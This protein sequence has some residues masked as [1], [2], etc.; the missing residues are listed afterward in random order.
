MNF[1]AKHQ[2]AAAIRHLAAERPRG[3][4]P[5]CQLPIHLNVNLAVEKQHLRRKESPGDVL[6]RKKPSLNSDNPENEYQKP[7]R[8]RITMKTPPRMLTFQNLDSG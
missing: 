2:R 3:C 6:S 1:V 8:V 4:S 5:I 7:R